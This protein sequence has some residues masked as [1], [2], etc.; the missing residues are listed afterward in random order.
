MGHFS[1]FIGSEQSVPKWK[2]SLLYKYE[3]CYASL[4]VFC[5]VWF[6]FFID[7]DT[8]VMLCSNVHPISNTV[9]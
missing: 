9:L 5:L 2:R 7:T 1:R 4:V 3:L 8:A 6:F